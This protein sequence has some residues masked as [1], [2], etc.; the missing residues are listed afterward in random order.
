MSLDFLRKPNSRKKGLKVLVYGETGSGKS[1]FAL[2]FPKIVLVDSEDGDSWYENGERGKNIL[3]VL[4]TQSYDDLEDALDR[5]ENNTDEFS[6]FV[7]DSETKIYE[8]IQEA[9][10]AVEEA[11]ASRKGRD[12][13]DA[14]LSMRSWGKIKQLGSRLQ[15]AKIRLASQGINIVSIAQSSEVMEDAGNGTRVKVGEKPNMAKN[16]AYDYDVVIRLF[17]RD[18]K[19]YAQVEKDRTNTIVRGTEIE[20]PSYAIWQELLE[21]KSNQG[22]VVAKDFSKD[23]E[24][25]QKAY[26]EEVTG[27]MS[28]A[29]R[30]R[31]HLEGLSSED[32]KAFVLKMVEETGT[33]KVKEMNAEQQEKVLKL[34][35]D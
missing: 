30:V 3:G 35:A 34:M 2:S 21:G 18:N 19:F 6:T 10:Q 31:E 29:D 28:F 32:K 14:N 15:N 4:D 8:N 9:L 17:V 20:N 22:E 27:A 33:K 25:S 23:A 16:A 11:R 5:L 7:V 12:V 13:L 26:E 1:T 24:K